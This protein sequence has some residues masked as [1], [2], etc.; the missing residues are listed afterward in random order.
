MSFSVHGKC[1]FD[2]FCLLCVATAPL[3]AYN[4]LSESLC[5][6]FCCFFIVFLLFSKN[7]GKKELNY[8]VIRKVELNGILRGKTLKETMERRP[9]RR[10]AQI[11]LWGEVLTRRL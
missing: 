1:T 2:A 10:A 5:F 6:L 11:E 3:F 8:K 9:H 7:I 4:K